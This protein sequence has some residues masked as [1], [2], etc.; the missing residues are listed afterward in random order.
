[1]QDELILIWV[2]LWSCFV[3]GYFVCLK[4]VFCSFQNEILNLLQSR[5]GGA[6]E[7]CGISPRKRLVVCLLS[8]V[9]V[10]TSFFH[11]L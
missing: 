4:T 11:V 5:W 10:K 7:D 1:M 2:T 6:D 8:F 9:L 3:I